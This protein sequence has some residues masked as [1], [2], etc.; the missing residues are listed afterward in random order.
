MV[1]PLWKTVRNF[2]TKLSV[3]LLCDL[4]VLFLDIH[5]KE[6]N[7]YVCMKACTQVFTAGS[8]LITNTRKHPSCPTRRRMD[9]QA[10]AHPDSGLFAANKE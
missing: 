5:P 6:L 9:K 7:A 1:Q 4:V 2:L 3:L 10:V 8:F